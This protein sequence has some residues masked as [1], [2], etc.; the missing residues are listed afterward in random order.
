METLK[1][2]YN[3]V[4]KSEKLGSAPGSILLWNSSPVSLQI[5]NDL[6][7]E[8]HIGIGPIK[9][10]MTKEKLEETLL[11][12]RFCYTPLDKSCFQI[13]RDISSQNDDYT[14][15][16]QSSNLFIMVRYQKDRAAEISVD[17]G[18]AQ[19]FPVILYDMEVFSTQV[20]LLIEALTKYCPYECNHEDSLLSTEYL[21]PNLGIR[22]WR[23]D[24][25]H[26]KLLSDESYMRTMG[27]VIDD[28]YRYQ[29]FD[30]ITILK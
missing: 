15:R 27:Q 6:R 23:E 13:S 12:I 3:L 29:F 1:A 7:I 4:D 11:N 8:P 10:G 30:I 17:R 16:Y 24:V 14:V 28:M 5:L 22:L 25:F 21:F 9:I 18:A 20:E 26:P 2:K 19:H